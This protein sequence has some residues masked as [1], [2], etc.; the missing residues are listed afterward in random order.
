MWNFSFTLPSSELSQPLESVKLSILFL[1]SWF[2]CFSQIF[3][4]AASLVTNFVK[5]GESSNDPIAVFREDMTWVCSIWKLIKSDFVIFW[6]WRDRCFISRTSGKYSVVFLSQTHC[7]L[8]I[9]GT[10]LCTPTQVS[11]PP[12]FSC[13][14]YCGWPSR[15]YNSVL[16][17]CHL[18]VVALAAIL[19]LQKW[20]LTPHMTTPLRNMLEQIIQLN[21]IGIG[22][23]LKL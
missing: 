18:T 14:L 13:N 1:F 4:L 8:W 15:N 20:K 6:A 12:Q 3:P 23:E 9:P 5:S 16:K 21:S 11:P 19:T 10:F 2:L 22:Y 17:H 7:P